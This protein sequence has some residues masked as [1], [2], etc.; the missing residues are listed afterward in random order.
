MLMG[1][2]D[3]HNIVLVLITLI[4]PEHIAHPNKAAILL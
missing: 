3:T 1:H 2:C 4:T